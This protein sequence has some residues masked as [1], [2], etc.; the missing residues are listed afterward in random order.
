MPAARTLVSAAPHRRVG[1]IPCPWFQP[2]RIE[3]ESL[4]E[5]DFARVALF[6][7]H[8]TAISHQPF[9]VDLGDH[10]TYTPD[11][12][13][14]GRKVP[15]IVEVKP[16]SRARSP[17]TAQLLAQARAVLRASGYDFMVA[18]EQ[19]IRSDNR[20]ERAAVLLRHARSQIPQTTLDLVMHIAA[21]SS[22]C[23]L[24]IASLAERANV[25]IATILH[26]IG[27]RRLR[28][29]PSLHFGLDEIV[30]VVG[31]AP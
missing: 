17:R 19:Y 23:P 3:Y 11:F 31:V 28:V 4:L 25:P 29:G 22:T 26:L 14:I 7:P 16:E 12:L 9:K 21:A 15:L 6:E 20:H 2:N 10:R 18:T 24:T 13:L 8:V 1:I 30:S 5:R 27:R